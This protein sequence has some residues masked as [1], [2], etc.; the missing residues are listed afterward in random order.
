MRCNQRPGCHDLSG[1]FETEIKCSA[2]EK[3]GKGWKKGAI[4]AEDEL[5]TPNITV[6]L[7]SSEATL[8]DG[9]LHSTCVGGEVQHCAVHPNQQV[10]P[11]LDPSPPLL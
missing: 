2:V 1:C 4:A 10:K 8:L 9:R 5:G 6:R 3:W 11:N 7:P